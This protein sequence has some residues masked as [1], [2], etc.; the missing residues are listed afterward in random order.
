MSDEALAEHI[1][2]AA[3]VEELLPRVEEVAKSVIAGYEAG[4]RVFTFGNG[5]SAADAQ[6]LAAELVG[7]YLRERRPLA[8]TALSVDPSTV[9]SIANDYSFDDVFARQVRAQVSAGDVVIAFT[10]SGRARNVVAGIAAAREAD[11]V[12]V[13]F[14]GGDGGPAATEAELALVVPST[15]TARVQEIHLLLMHLIVDRVDSWAAQR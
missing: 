8:A 7:R 3:R 9:T 10:T 13:V 12:T 6:H 11:A 2:L 15:V 1:A 14:T 5:G 4:H